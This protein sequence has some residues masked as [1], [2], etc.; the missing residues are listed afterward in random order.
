MK[1]DF[2]SPT[3]DYPAPRAVLTGHDHEVVCVSVCAELGL[4]ISGAKEG[5]CLV[6]TITGDLL[7]ALEGTENCL[8]PR[9]I[10]V[11]SEGH[12]IIYYERGRFSNFSI[13]G[14]LL[15]QMEI[16]DSTRAILLSSDG[17]NLVTGGDNGVVEVWQ[18]CDFKQLYIYPGCD[19]GIRAMDL[20]H[21]QRT[22]I[23]GMASG[24]IV[25]FNIDFNRWHY[26]HQNRY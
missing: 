26:E 12:C 9:L 14:K 16:N 6:H 25:A 10:S 1:S 3:G 20:S 2:V 22:L 7:R 23:T 8:Y 13:N 18:A 15:A 11:S 4:V 5:P 21:D 19:A 17:Q 24:S